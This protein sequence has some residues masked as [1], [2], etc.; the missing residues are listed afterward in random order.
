MVRGPKRWLVEGHIGV[1]IVHVYIINLLP[2]VFN[3]VVVDNAFAP[4]EA[5]HGQYYVRVPCSTPMR[6]Q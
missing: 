3:S 2:F 6:G 1:V 4:V 5:F